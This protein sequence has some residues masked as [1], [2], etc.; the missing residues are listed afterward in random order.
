MNRMLELADMK[1]A[2][3]TMFK[4]LKGKKKQ[5]NGNYI[6]VYVCIEKHNIWNEDFTG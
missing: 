5:K 2:I 6:S 4:D 1:D 3:I